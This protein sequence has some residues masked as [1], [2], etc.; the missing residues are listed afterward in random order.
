MPFGVVIGLL[1]I[2]THPII[3]NILKYFPCT[4]EIWILYV[5]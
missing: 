5:P 3:E 1:K 2:L 4:S